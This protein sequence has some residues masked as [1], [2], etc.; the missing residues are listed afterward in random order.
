MRIV[1]TVASLYLLSQSD[2]IR[3][4]MPNPRS[5]N[6]ENNRGSH[7]N[8]GRNRRKIRG[9]GRG[10]GQ[11]RPG[12]RKALL[13]DI[14]ATTL[15]AVER[16]SYEL[17]GTIYDLK[18]SVEYMNSKTKYYPEQSNLSD[19]QT[20]RLGQDDG[21]E[22]DGGENKRETVTVTVSEHSSLVGIRQM[23]ESLENLSVG[24]KTIGVLNFASAKNP[25][26]G[27]I[28]GASAQEES[29]ARSSTIYSSLLTDPAQ[30]FYKT[31]RHDPKKGYYS[32]AM[33]YSPKVLFFR[34]DNGDW[35]PPI[36]AEVVTSCAVNAGVVRRYL[37][38]DNS[39]DESG[40][41]GAMKE[42]MARVLYLF[43]RHGVRNLVLGSFG[44]GVFRNR[45]ALVARVW[46]ELLV[47]EQ[48][49]FARSFDRV[50]MAIID[51]KTCEVF[52]K[53]FGGL[54]DEVVEPEN[55]D[56]SDGP[57]DGDGGKAEDDKESGQEEEDGDQAS[58]SRL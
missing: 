34:A 11:H 46:K 2:Y 13:V 4:N 32:H 24:S 48:A 38:E 52:K 5:Q 14:A 54:E 28:K 45:V 7:P 29:L 35:K 22:G 20:R 26:G 33:V 44:T 25:G 30:S 57:G 6:N 42:R 18:E 58:G 53:V 12:H 8:R 55:G 43:E 15:E 1:L 41:D 19:W 9:K 16:G 31:H 47:G 10:E 17:D 51:N 27:F 23:A 37:K 49:R 50:D 39:E 3:F 56:E 21:E 40:I 36:A